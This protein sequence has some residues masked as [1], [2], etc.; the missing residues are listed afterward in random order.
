M[1]DY[2]LRPCAFKVMLTEEE[3]ELLRTRAANAEMTESEF[4][5]CWLLDK[6]DQETIVQ[7]KKLRE[8]IQNSIHA[9]LAT[10]K[11]DTDKLAEKTF[12]ELWEASQKIMQTLTLIGNDDHFLEW[13]RSHDRKEDKAQNIRRWQTR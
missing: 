12:I 13:R 8:A 11:V 9:I 5:R 6:P 7:L 1:K 3:R 4:F 10:G 2:R